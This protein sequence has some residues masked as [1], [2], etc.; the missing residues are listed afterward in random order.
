M[1]T[2]TLSRSRLGI[3]RHS[4]FRDD[5]ATSRS[6]QSWPAVGLLACHLRGGT[7][8]GPALL[9][10]A[11]ALRSELGCHLAGDPGYPHPRYHDR[12]CPGSARDSCLDLAWAGSGTV[13]LAHHSTDGPDLCFLV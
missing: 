10:T 8:I 2:S 13:A 12:R 3:C 9:H 4:D 1:G 11:R 5:P 6:L 7:P